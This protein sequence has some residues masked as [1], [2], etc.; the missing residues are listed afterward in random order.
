M[1]NQQ[2]KWL[3]KWLW[4]SLLC[5]IAGYIE[6]HVPEYNSYILQWIFG[7]VTGYLTMWDTYK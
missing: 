2:K 1:D 3:C 4:I 6:H 7:L 5:I